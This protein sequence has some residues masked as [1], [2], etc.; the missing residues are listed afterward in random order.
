[1]PMTSN[2][3]TP[4]DPKQLWEQTKLEGWRRP[5]A[6]FATG[7]LAFLTLSGLAIFALPFNLWN[8]HAVVTHTA[9]GLLFALPLAWYLVSHVVAYWTYPLTHTKFTGWASGAM[10]VVCSLSGVVLTWEAWFGRKISPTWREIHIVTTFGTVAFLAPH[11]VAVWLRERKRRADPAAQPLLGTLRGHW[12]TAFAALAVPILLTGA[13]C[14]VVRPVAMNHQFPAEYEKDPYGSGSPFS[15]SL[16]KTSTG[17]AFDP[18]SL[19][20]SRSCGTTGCHEQ[21]VEEWEP[22]AHRYAALDAGFQKIQSVMAAQNGPVSTRYCGGCHDPISLF[23]GTKNIGVADLTALVGIQEGI[24]CLSCHAIEQTDVKGNANYVMHEPPRYV[25]ELHDGPVAKRL[26][27]FLLRAYPAQHVASLSRRMFK[28]PEFCAACH[29]QFIDKEV[30]KVGWVQLQNQYDNWKNSRWNHPGEPEKTLECRECHMPLIE[31]TDPAAGDAADFNRTPNDGKHRSHRFLGANQYIP[32]VHD[33]PHKDEHVALIGQWL[34]GEYDIPEIADRWRKGPAVPIELEAPPEAKS[35]ATVPVRVHILNNKVGHDFPTGPLDIIQAW[36][37]VIVKDDAGK[38]LFH[39]GSVDDKHFVETG[40][41]MFKA[42][43]VDRYGN[44][45]DRHNLWEMVG[46]RFKRS[47][48]PGEEEVASYELPCSGS[49]SG[50]GRD[51]PQDQSI[52][53]E[54]PADALGQ[55]HVTANLNYRKFDQYLLNFA[56]GDKS[57]LTAPVT[58]MSTA[59]CSIAVMPAKSGE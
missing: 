16:A 8:E 42:E 2:D 25:Y 20:G 55:L 17:G 48:F 50:V 29:K 10:V 41:F 49:A 44:L 39:S 22:S 19:S 23:S 43:P 46:V 18:R 1:M 21:I 33:L 15:P 58:T 9:I 57:G 40:T 7:V 28:T 12:K 5:L 34:K 32:I 36:V 45:I 11:L 27:D 30:N 59:E 35:G 13:L 47:L 54:V 52:K 38:V 24:S 6:R 37:E 31:S 3:P 56:F 26:S 14:V 51:L 53:V 4:L